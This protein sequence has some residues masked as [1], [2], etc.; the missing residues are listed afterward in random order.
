MSDPASAGRKPAGDVV[1]AEFVTISGNAEPSAP[2]ESTPRA[3]VFDAPPASGMDILRGG[4]DAAAIVGTRRGGPVFWLG[5][6][7]MVLAA[8]WVSGGHALV[9]RPA[10]ATAPTSTR[11]AASSHAGLRIADVVSRTE[12]R[13]ERGHIL[14]DGSVANDGSAPARL[15]GLDIV[16]TDN[17]GR[18]TRYAL[19][20][21]GRAIAPGERF[22]FSSRLDAP[23]EGAKSVT[24][25]FSKEGTD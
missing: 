13:G 8:F 19:G 15:A 3:A 4:T 6:V 25:D 9:S 18:T 1:D 2:R 22:A 14:V 21:G 17:S 10:Q 12:K 23:R 16:V 7:V 24:V 11:P 5:G 20:T